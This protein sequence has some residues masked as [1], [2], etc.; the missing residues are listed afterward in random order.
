MLNMQNMQI[1]MLKICW[2]YVRNIFKYAKNMLKI[3]I[4][5]ITWIWKIC[6]ICTK[7]CKIK[8]QQYA[9]YALKYAK[10]V[11]YMRNCDMQRICKK[12]YAK[13]AK[14][15]RGRYAKYALRPQLCWWLRLGT[16]Y[17][18]ESRVQMTEL[19]TRKRLTWTFAT[20]IIVD[21][22][23]SAGLHWY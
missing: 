21:S 16:Y 23:R 6:R 3:C 5:W 8:C 14:H 4:T 19:L 1:I 20:K 15:V 11:K 12:T 9:K 18:S 10:Y 13:F 2:K 7:I 17:R 22:E